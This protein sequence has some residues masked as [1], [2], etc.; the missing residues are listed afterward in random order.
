MRL[1]TDKLF[2]TPD[3]LETLEHHAAYIPFSQIDLSDRTHRF[4]TP[5]PAISESLKTDLLRHGQ[6]EPILIQEISNGYRILDG[7]RRCD[8]VARLLEE[9]RPW[10]KMLAQVTPAQLPLSVRFPLLVDK[11]VRGPSQFGLM[12]TARFIETFYEE[13]MSAEEMARSAAFSVSDILGYLEVARAPLA[14]AELF[15]GVFLSPTLAL[16]LM[17]RFT[18]WIDSP[19]SDQAVSIAARVLDHAGEPLTL[20]S[21]EFLLNFYW[22]DRPFMAPPRKS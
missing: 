11:N 20:R 17:R 10:E 13:G 16:A 2:P 7:Y 3:M 19:Y 6:L 4:R 14:L 1:S 5:N 15:E 9:G 22:A 8:A 12:E 18:Q 21:W